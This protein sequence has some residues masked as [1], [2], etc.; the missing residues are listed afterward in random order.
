M[1]AAGHLAIT[2]LPVGVEDP[3]NLNRSYY[4]VVAI[5]GH[6]TRSGCSEYAE[7]PHPYIW[8]SPPTTVRVRQDYRYQ[9]Q[10][11]QSLGD[12]QYR[13]EKPIYKFWEREQLSFSLVKGPEWLK[14]C[15]HTGSLT[16]AVPRDSTGAYPV[17]IRVTAS[18][19]NR[20][21]KDKFTEDLPERSSHQDFDLVVC[22]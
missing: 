18:F 1:V 21:G 11:I 19:E 15:P 12:L 14:V 8:T 17:R 5:D 22:D 7:M 20:T 2:N 4:R 6:G 9:P 10:A 13:Y 3:N 16:G